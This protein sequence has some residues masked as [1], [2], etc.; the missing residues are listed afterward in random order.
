MSNFR[1]K[2]IDVLVSTTIIE[3]GLDVP[4]ATVI[5][6]ENS[7]RMGLS[8]LH[9]LRGRVGRGNKKS[10]CILIFKSGLSELA[11]KRI[12]I[13]RKCS[14]GFDI[15]KEDLDLR[16]PG[17]ILGKKQKGDIN[18]KIANIARDYR[19]IEDTKDCAEKIS[20]VASEKL[21]RRW[22]TEEIEIGKA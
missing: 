20:S 8:Q 4:N 9:Q 11:R 21:A 7:E 1:N 22:I 18:F 17:E 10:S 12:D 19:F 14:N 6:I 3:V 16:G 15:A 13:L 2:K 5:I